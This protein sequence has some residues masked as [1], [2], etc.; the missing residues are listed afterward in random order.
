MLIG[1]RT[2]YRSYCET[3]EVIV[4]EDEHTK[5]EGSKLCAYSG[6]DMSLCP[7]TKGARAACLVDKGND[8]TELNEEDE[9]ACSSGNGV[10]E[11]CA[12][13]GVE[14]T[15]R[16][17]V[18]REERACNDTC[19]ERAVNF[20]SNKSETDSDYGRDE[21]PEATLNLACTSAGF[22]FC[23]DSCAIGTV[24]RAES[25]AGN[26]GNHESGNDHE[27]SNQKCDFC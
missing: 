23:A 17:K 10:N 26:A 8:D 18:R 7:F 3:V 14:S 24:N 12:D 20:L 22:A 16:S 15:G 21:S 11:T 13:S 5:D 1:Y 9:D 25:T 6:L 27:H 4:D 2:H 19:K